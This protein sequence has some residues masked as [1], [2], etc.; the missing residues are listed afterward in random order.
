MTPGPTVD[1]QCTPT[2]SAIL[3]GRQ[4]VRSGTFKVRGIEAPQIWSGTKGDVQTAVRELNVEVRPLLDELIV[5]HA[6][7]Y[8]TR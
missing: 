5:E 1:A 6:T 2:R 3:T 4:S 7:G 8:I